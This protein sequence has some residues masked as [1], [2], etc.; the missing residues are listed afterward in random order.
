VLLHHNDFLQ[1]CWSYQ[2]VRPLLTGPRCRVDRRHLPNT[3]SV[4]F[5][6][7]IQLIH[8]QS[9]WSR[10]TVFFR[11]VGLTEFTLQK[12]QFSD[13]DLI[14]PLPGTLARDPLLSVHN[15]VFPVLA[16]YC[17]V[18]TNSYQLSSPQLRCSRDLGGHSIHRIIFKNFVRVKA[19]FI[20]LPGVLS[21]S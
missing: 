9:S 19:T 6:F 16:S 12:I 11:N 7:N 18:S 2:G 13:F 5:C 1:K 21:S 10:T 17:C 14:L 15:S 8:A 20:S 4:F 3:M